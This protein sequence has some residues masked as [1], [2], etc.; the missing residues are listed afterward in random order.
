[1]LS[2]MRMMNKFMS[3][4]KKQSN[5]FLVEGYQRLLNQLQDCKK[6]DSKLRKKVDIKFFDLSN[7]LSRFYKR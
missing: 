5:K 2:L 4:H 1:M 7:T 6:S 3:S